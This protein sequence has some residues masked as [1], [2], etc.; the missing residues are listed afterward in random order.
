M[1]SD[2]DRILWDDIGLNIE[3][4]FHMLQLLW[5]V[6]IP[7]KMY[8]LVCFYSYST[9]FKKPLPEKNIYTFVMRVCACGISK[10]CLKLLLQSLLFNKASNSELFESRDTDE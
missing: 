8:L 2:D 1:L 6:Q 4:K 9:I 3:W 10:K 7:F 5:P